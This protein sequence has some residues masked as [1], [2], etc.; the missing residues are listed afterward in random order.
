MVPDTET[1]GLEGLDDE[2]EGDDEPFD[3]EEQV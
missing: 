2:D 3:D 1:D